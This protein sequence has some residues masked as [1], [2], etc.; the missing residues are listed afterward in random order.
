[1]GETQAMRALERQPYIDALDWATRTDIVR[2][3]LRDCTAETKSWT[4]DHAGGGASG[5][6][7]FRIR[8]DA[9]VEGTAV[10]GG[11]C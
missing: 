11:S 2:A 8:G 7:L 4:N 1:M 6:Q 3:A 5:S 9:R 10:P